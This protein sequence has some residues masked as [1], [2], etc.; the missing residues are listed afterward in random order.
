MFPIPGTFPEILFFE[1]VHIHINLSPFGWLVP[2]LP[3]FDQVK[4]NGNGMVFYGTS[5]QKGYFVPKTVN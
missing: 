5:A 1:M 2:F 3:P 4:W